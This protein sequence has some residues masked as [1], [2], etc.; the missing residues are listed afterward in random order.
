[1]RG[2]HCAG[3][4]D[5]NAKIVVHPFTHAHTHT[6]AQLAPPTSPRAVQER[7]L[8]IQLVSLVFFSFESTFFLQVGNI[9]LTDPANL[10]YFK[11]LP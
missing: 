3:K 8:K 6:H 7:H 10:K 2:N 4:K 11:C 1:M 9:F 5:G